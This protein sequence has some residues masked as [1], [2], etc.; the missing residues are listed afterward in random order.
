MREGDSM[1]EKKSRKPSPK[2]TPKQ[3]P[4]LGDLDKTLKKLELLEV[5]RNLTDKEKAER[6]ASLASNS[7]G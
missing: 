4:K 1:K 3:L 5:G 2:P 7:Q 6:R